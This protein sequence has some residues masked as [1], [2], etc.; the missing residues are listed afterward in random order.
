MEKKILMESLILVCV[1]S[2][3]RLIE[4]SQSPKTMVSI[5]FIGL[6]YDVVKGNPHSNLYDPGFRRAVVEITYNKESKS[7]D[8]QWLVPD[9][10][11]VLQAR[12]CD[13]KVEYDVVTGM[14]SYQRSLSRDVSI[15]N[16]AWNFKFSGSDEYQEVKEGV[17]KHHK[18]FVESVA[19]C[20][21]YKARIRS[22]KELKVTEEFKEAVDELPVTANDEEYFK[23]IQR[24]GTH[25]A[26]EMIMGAKKIV[27][28]EFDQVVWAELHMNNNFNIKS[29][30]EL[31][32]LGFTTKSVY[33]AGSNDAIKT[34]F[35]RKRS[36]YKV[37]FIGNH[38][39]EDGKWETWTRTS[40]NMPYPIAFTL[41]PLTE[42]FT[43]K[44]ISNHNSSHI[45]AKQKLLGEAIK[46]YCGGSVKTLRC[47]SKR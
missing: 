17:Y 14:N 26:S 45:Q 5:D 24:F 4:C 1:I 37:S 41:S 46:T 23:F 2:T 18:Y 25:Y 35:E 42:L 31:S 6:G 34:E 32:F 33:G 7:S 16:G 13:Y 43:V 30:A 15:P 40:G 44:F 28:S 20:S 36:S 29:G 3:V 19:K 38:P 22:Y 21:S 9:N 47:A 10:V 27:R 39:P 8:N 12:S 11:Q